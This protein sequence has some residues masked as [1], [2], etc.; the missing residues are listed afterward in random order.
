MHSNW[1]IV[2]NLKGAYLKKVLNKYQSNR[3]KITGNKLIQIY[4]P[5]QEKSFP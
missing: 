3:K 2:S 1:I 4:L 5:Y